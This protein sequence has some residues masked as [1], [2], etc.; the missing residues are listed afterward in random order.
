MKALLQALYLG[1]TMHSLPQKV[2]P[3]EPLRV[4]DNLW[5]NLVLDLVTIVCFRIAKGDI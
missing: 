2:R 1:Y 3:F 4:L 5:D